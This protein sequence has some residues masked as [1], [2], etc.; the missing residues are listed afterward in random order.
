MGCQTEAAASNDNDD[1]EKWSWDYHVAATAGSS[2]PPSWGWTAFKGFK[3]MPPLQLTFR[4]GGGYDPP[5]AAKDED[6]D[7]I[8]GK[9][10]RGDE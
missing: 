3:C 4:K 9:R 10:K 2:Y 8:A 6:K 7:K 5:A 1:D